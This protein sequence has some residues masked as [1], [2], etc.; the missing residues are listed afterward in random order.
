MPP[1]L[2]SSIFHTGRAMGFCSD[3]PCCWLF[4]EKVTPISVW[5]SPTQHQTP[6][7]WRI[8][9]YLSPAFACS[10]LWVVLG[11]INNHIV[12][13]TDC[14]LLHMLAD[15]EEVTSISVWLF[16][17]P[18]PRKDYTH[19]YCLP[20]HVVSLECACIIHHHIMCRTNSSLSDM[21]ADQEEIIPISSCHCVIYHD[22]WRWVLH[23]V[24]LLYVR[25]KR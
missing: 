4:P 16:T 17:T 20:L 24:S 9:P 13:W 15:Q 2:Y 22:A 8:N 19:I 5:L 3:L 25:K 12:C 6:S 10:Q 21:L 11:V 18:I 23:S 14:S 7:L 1:W